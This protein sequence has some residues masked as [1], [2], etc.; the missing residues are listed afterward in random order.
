MKSLLRINFVFFLILRGFIGLSS[1]Q[2]I[3]ARQTGG[4][5]ADPTQVATKMVSVTNDWLNGKLSTPGVNVEVREVAR[6]NDGGRLIVQYHVFVTGAPKDQ[7]YGLATWPI[8]SAGPAEQMKGLSIGADGI[9]MCAGRT[10]D[11]CGD[12]NK[13]DDPVEFAFSP[14]RGEVIRLGL[15]SADG[16]LKVLFAVVPDPIVSTSK[17]CS[18]EVLRVLP[19]FEATLVRAK[20]FQPNEEL[21]FASKSYDESHENKVKADSNGG[22][23]TALLPFVKNHQ[24]GVTNLQLKGASCVAEISFSWGK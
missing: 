3:S 15:V 17:N 11:Q 1:P 6:T 22:Y 23:A 10:P 14:V 12:P 16:K 8:N 20:G 7:T 19:K 13:K 18:L 9:V 21:V 5:A 24:D 4:N 2:E